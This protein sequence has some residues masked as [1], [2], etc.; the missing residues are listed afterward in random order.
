MATND[1]LGSERGPLETLVMGCCQV[2]ARLTALATACK[3]LESA[4]SGKAADARVQKALAKLAKV[5]NP[6]L[7]PASAACPAPGSSRPPPSVDLTQ[8]EEAPEP[9]LQAT[10]AAAAAEP[11]GATPPS[12]A[13][14]AL[15][16][17][18]IHQTCLHGVRWRLQSLPLKIHSSL[19]MSFLVHAGSS[20]H[21]CSGY[22]RSDTSRR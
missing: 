13:G 11:A 10:D 20:R 19:L 3:A 18:V 8:P 1:R 2:A 9:P 21:S 14:L 22:W 12:Q 16:C 4:G 7:G 15:Q 17:L 6:V 5:E